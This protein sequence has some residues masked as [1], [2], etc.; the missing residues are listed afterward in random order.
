MVLSDFVIAKVDFS[1][2]IVFV[3]TA[4]LTLTSVISLYF[5]APEGVC[6]RVH[7]VEVDVTVDV[8]VKVDVLRSMLVDTSFDV[9]SVFAIVVG[10]I[11]AAV[12]ADCSASD[13]GFDSEIEPAPFLFGDEVF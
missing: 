13:F 6:F 12:G 9:D 1:L 11:E 3:S 2:V 5:V 10:R 7:C 4:D 8:V